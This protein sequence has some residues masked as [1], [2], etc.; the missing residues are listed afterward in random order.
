M[1]DSLF[2]LLFEGVFSETAGPKPIRTAFSEVPNWSLG[3]GDATGRPKAEP[4][5]LSRS[6]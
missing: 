4:R 6:Q 5:S 3:P 1:S 2:C